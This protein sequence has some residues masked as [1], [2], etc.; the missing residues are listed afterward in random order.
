MNTNLSLIP[1]PLPSPLSDGDAATVSDL[2]SRR[3]ATT[4]VADANAAYRAELVEAYIEV[5]R[6]GFWEDELALLAEAALY[7]KA[8]PNDVVPLADELHG[9]QI[10]FAPVG[11]AA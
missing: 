7:D 10:G 5:C 9:T 6:T 3:R 2:S 8:N 4:S 11:V 1:T